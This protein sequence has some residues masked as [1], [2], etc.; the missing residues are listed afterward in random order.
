MRS[1]ILTT[2]LRYPGGK[3]KWTKLLYEYLPDMRDYE[4][5][6]EPFLGGGSMPIEITKRYPDMRIWVNDLYPALYNFWTQLQS[7]GSEMSEHLLK[8]KESCVSGDVA[9]TILGEQK[10]IIND[11]VSSD[12]DKAVAFYYANKNSFSGLTEAGGFAESSHEMTFTRQNIMKL[13]SFQKLIRNW[14]ITNEDCSV[15]LEKSPKT[16][17]YLDPPYELT[18]QNSNNLYGKR[19]SMHEGFNHDLFA[20]QCNESGMDC[21]IS[22]NADQ[23][24]K[25]RFDGWEQAELDWTYTMQ[26]VGDYMENQKDRKELLLLNY[27]VEQ[28]SLETFFS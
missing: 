4:E 9:K 24:V 27:K 7:S 5:W 28:G 10:E 3:S 16:F 19:G 13:V 25:D 11:D 22:Y 2:P 1:P 21:M 17:V 12:F 14:K 18:K 6:R 26:S 8:I 23:S 20:K 15:L